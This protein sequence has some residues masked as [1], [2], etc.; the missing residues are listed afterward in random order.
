MHTRDWHFR[1][2]RFWSCQRTSAT[3]WIYVCRETYG[4]VFDTYFYHVTANPACASMCLA[5]WAVKLAPWLDHLCNFHLPH[6]NHVV[7]CFFF[8][9]FKCDHWLF[10]VQC[11][12][13]GGSL[14]SDIITL[15]IHCTVN[16]RRLLD[17]ASYFT[18]LIT[19]KLLHVSPTFASLF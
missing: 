15:K 10:P 7:F 2:T 12:A 5:F 1:E 17:D 18:K 19:L 14:L 6:I 8:V 9:S 3:L 4:R 11:Q 13:A 16:N